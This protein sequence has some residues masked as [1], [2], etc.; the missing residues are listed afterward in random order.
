MWSWIPVPRR[1]LQDDR[2]L[3]LA[4]EDRAVYL[5]LYLAADEHGRFD[6]GEMALR[7]NAGIVTGAEV[8]PTLERLA[9]LR[10]VYLYERNG[11]RF[12]LLDHFDEDITRDHTKKRPSPN[13]PAPPADVWKAAGC[14]GVFRGGQDEPHTETE[15]QPS[16]GQTNCQSVSNSDRSAI[17]QRSDGERLKIE[18]KEREVI[19]REQARAESPGFRD[20][21]EARMGWSDPRP[22][23]V[24]IDDQLVAVPEKCRQAAIAWLVE[25]AK[26][27]RRHGGALWSECKAEMIAHEF[28]ARL[29]D[30]ASVGVEPFVR[31]VEIMIERG[32]G[33]GR[34]MPG[35][36]VNYL[37]KIVRSWSAEQDNE[38]QATKK[39][40]RRRIGLDKGEGFRRIGP[41]PK[42][43][44]VDTEVDDSLSDVM[45]G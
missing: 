26:V 32:K 15:D 39:K 12:G 4:L 29:S 43:G 30:T 5:S 41:A 35:E 6:A 19:S 1:L 11:S 23:L 44:S 3:N 16:V 17:D 42:P 25:V 10:L 2:L 37:D 21:R 13:H 7:R 38:K 40:R 27:R 18:K 9:E 22:E 14:S 24:S 33:F 28:A 45:E 20:P 36:G 31:G 8:T 34:G